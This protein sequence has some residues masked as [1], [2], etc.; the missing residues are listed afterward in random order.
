MSEQHA[1]YGVELNS[2]FDARPAER[3]CR[4]CGH[5]WPHGA[6]LVTESEPDVGEW[7]SN[8]KHSCVSLEVTS[9]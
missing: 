2:P 6:I 3:T 5:Q 9:A 1:V 7:A 4:A 8:F